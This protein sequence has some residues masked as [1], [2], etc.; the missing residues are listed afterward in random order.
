MSVKHKNVD[1]DIHIN[2]V[3]EGFLNTNLIPSIEYK[4]LIIYFKRFLRVR[5]LPDQWTWYLEIDGSGVDNYI[6]AGRKAVV[7]AFDR[8]IKKQMLLELDT[9]R[10]LLDSYGPMGMTEEGVSI[11]KLSDKYLQLPIK[12]IHPMFFRKYDEASGEVFSQEV[13]KI[14]SN[15]SIISYLWNSDNHKWEVFNEGGGEWHQP[16]RPVIKILRK[17][18]TNS[19][20]KLLSKIES[21]VYHSYEDVVKLIDAGV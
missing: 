16:S 18:F 1:L 12:K 19:T 6:K 17:Y 20:L 5:S 4:I 13:E 15:D 10:N 2:V 8:F 14:S 11:V 21:Q 9:L 3:T 7:E